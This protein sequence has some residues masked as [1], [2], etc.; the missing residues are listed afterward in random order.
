VLPARPA[1]AYFLPV[2]YEAHCRACH[3]LRAPEDTSR[4]IVV[5]GFAISHRKQG[6]ELL[7]EL[8]GGYLRGL[9]AKNPPPLAM[10]MGPGGRVE[11]R[12]VPEP[13]AS[14]L[15]NEA[16]RMT[17]RALV[18]LTTAGGCAKCHDTPNDKVTQ[19]PNRTVWF[20]ASVFSHASHRSAT[21]ATCHPG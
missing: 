5:P 10:P 8:D 16:D 11:P 15:R 12:P 3:P 7:D 14:N 21:C 17:V 6:S 13:V 9:I 20:Q 19:V 18:H 2:N 1:G 4:G